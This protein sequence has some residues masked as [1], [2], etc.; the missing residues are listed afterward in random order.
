MARTPPKL[1][2]CP[3]FFEILNSGSMS[4]IA[5]MRQRQTIIFGF[6]SSIWFLS[7][8]MQ[9]SRSVF[10]GSRFPRAAFDY[11]C[12]VYVFVLSRPIIASMSSKSLPALPTRARL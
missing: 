7:Q 3:C 12:Y 5:A 10:S 8:P 1:Y 4:V 2:H 6:I 11:V 9:A